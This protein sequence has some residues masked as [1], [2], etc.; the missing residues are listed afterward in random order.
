M[1]S[2]KRNESH[3]FAE[4]TCTLKPEGAYQVLARASVGG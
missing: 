1:M 4:R 3:G 2:A